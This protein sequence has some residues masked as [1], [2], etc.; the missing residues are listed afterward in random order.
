VKSPC[1]QRT[2]RISVSR[3]PPLLSQW[4]HPLSSLPLLQSS[5]VRTRPQPF[6]REPLPWGFFPLR[7]VSPWSPRPRA[8]QARSVPPSEFLT[9]STVCSSSGLAGL[10]HP[11]A[12]SGIHP[13]GI[14]PPQQPCHL[15][16]A[17]C[18]LDVSPF[19]LPPAC[20]TGA[21][22]TAPPSG[23]CSAAESV[24][25]RRGL[26][27]ATPDSLLG[28]TSSGLSS[29]WPCFRFHGRSARGLCRRAVQ[30]RPRDGPSASYRPRLQHISLEMRRPARGFR[31]ASD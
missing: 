2:L 14:S 16:G 9:P 21:R 5:P 3:R 4:V 28:F 13:S 18:P 30:A 23:P 24:A 11:A 6:G 19:S 10:F 20:A 27:H 29:P 15:I 26:A 22:K 25:L 7:D 17:P 31:P 8:S 1:F 12:T